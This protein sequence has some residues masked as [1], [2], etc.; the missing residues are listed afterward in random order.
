[1]AEDLVNLLEIR[2]PGDVKMQEDVDGDVKMQENQEE[3]DDEELFGL[4]ESF[5]SME[6]SS[7]N[8]TIDC[9]TGF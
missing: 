2:S 5:N 8:S 4:V 6:I 9:L 3:E 1:M 7:F